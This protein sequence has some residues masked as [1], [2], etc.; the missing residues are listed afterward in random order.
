ME[1]TVL[2]DLV[3]RDRR[4]DRPALVVP[5]LGRSYDYRRFCTTSWKVGNFLTHLGVRAG[6][7]VAIAAEPAPEPVLT[8][9]GAALLGAPVEFVD[10]GAPED[11][12]ALVVPTARLGEFEATPGRKRV[13]YGEAP[14][15]PDVSFFERDVWSENPTEPPDRVAPDATFL[16]R[17]GEGGAGTYDHRTVL[18]SAASVAEAWSLA[19]GD[20]VAVRASLTHPGAVVAGLVAPVL[21]GATVL[22]PDGGTRGT[23]AVTTGEAPEGSVL[24][25]EGVLP[26]R[27][28]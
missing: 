15:D 14:G 24:S 27:G 18:A 1:F 26:D 23:H 21:A 19:P 3:A 8:C 28:P 11:A 22:L 17:T 13:A 5:G 10:D 7:P 20:R 9:Y 12:R 16:R 4:G 6:R 25:P 2:G